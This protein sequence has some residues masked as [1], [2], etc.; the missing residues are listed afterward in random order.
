MLFIYIL[1]YENNNIFNMEIP[2][3]FGLLS[4]L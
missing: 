1:Q 3:Y 4:N 2:Q